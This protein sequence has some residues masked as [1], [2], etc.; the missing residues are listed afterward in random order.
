MASRPSV[1]FGLPVKHPAVIL[2]GLA[3]ILEVMYV[4]LAVWVRGLPSGQSIY[5][6]APLGG[7]IMAAMS[8]YCIS[9]SN[10]LVNLLVGYAMAV[11]NL[12]LAVGLFVIAVAWLIGPN[13]LLW[14][15]VV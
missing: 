4:I 15:L 5:Y 9:E 1:T 10:S 3:L 6:R 7:A 8:L 12:F 13:S 11:L 2:N 14:R